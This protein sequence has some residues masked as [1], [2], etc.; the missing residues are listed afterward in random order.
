VPEVRRPPQAG[1]S[2]T[3]YREAERVT[4]D[5][6]SLVPRAEKVQAALPAAARDA[7]FEL[8]LHPAKAYAQVADLF[9]AAVRNKLYAAQGR[10][11][12]HDAAARV[13]ALFQADMG[14]R[15]V[16]P[17]VVLLEVVV[18]NHVQHVR[19][20]RHVGDVDIGQGHGNGTRG[21]EPLHCGD[22]LTFDGR[23]EIGRRAGLGFGVN[24]DRTVHPIERVNEGVGGVID[25]IANAPHDDGGVIAIPQHHV[26]SVAAPHSSNH[27]LYP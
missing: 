24:R 13:K 6:D 5:F 17:L 9:I 4:A 8:V 23:H 26:L 11:G 21:V 1:F 7:F 16:V 19:H 14:I 2:L 3:D 18:A 12:A 20:T 22:Q 10:A 27:S 15:F 25:F